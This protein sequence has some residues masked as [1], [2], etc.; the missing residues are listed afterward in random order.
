MSGRFETALSIATPRTGRPAAPK[1]IAR[2]MWVVT[3]ALLGVWILTYLVLRLPGSYVH[4][5]LV[6]AIGVALMNL[7]AHTW[8]HPEDEAG[9]MSAAEEIGA[10]NAGG[11]REPE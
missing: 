2:L 11:E 8:T 4:T 1:A 3:A 5:F 10:R 7:I 6:A 9:A